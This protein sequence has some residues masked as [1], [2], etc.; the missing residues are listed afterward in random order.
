MNNFINREKEL[1]QLNTLYRSPKS[2]LVIVYGRRRLGKT[3]LLKEFSQHLP[4]CYFMAD[5][6]GQQSL[7]SNIA[8]ALSLAL[9]E[10]LLQRMEY[11]SWYDLFATFDRFR[12]KGSKFIFIID[13]YQ[14]LC[15]ADPAFSSYIQKW[16]DEKWRYD[17]I[18]FIL[19]GSVTSMMYKETLAESSPLYGRASAHILL[20]P[21]SYRH[22]Q[23]FLPGKTENDLIE[24]FALSGGVPRYMELLQGYNSFTEALTNLVL[25]KNGILYSEARYLLH[26]E[27]S[28]P[29][30]CWSILN[31]LGSGTTK[32]SEL[33]SRLGLPANQLT[34]YIDLLKDLFL[35]RREVPV[36][37]KNPAKSK[38]GI[39][40][41]DDFFIR[42]WFGAIYPYESFLEFDQIELT[43][44][45]LTPL[46]RAHI[47]YCYE[48]I[49]REFIKL[50]IHNFDVV[51]L[52]R[53][54]GKN[55][56]IDV[57]G[58]DSDNRIS[59]A[60]ECKWSHKMVGRSI[61]RDLHQ[62]IEHNHLPLSDNPT[63]CL[64]SRTGFSDDLIK[65]AKNSSTNIIL[66]GSLW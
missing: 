20:A 21:F 23:D 66:T 38:K 26:E 2:E 24:M 65:E 39:Y 36:L 56:E 57:C 9:N 25:S 14:Y 61:L 7:K 18:L 62:K 52:G 16:W 12:D 5:K 37:E 30:T 13:E 34:R 33:G 28:T 47:A 64:F 32:I 10:P 59:L 48:Q 3:Y 51:R 31:A 55:Y 15:Q 40:L 4:H 22:I 43:L 58:V 27:I 1:S 35:V 6:A 46:I 53:Q 50:N 17:N 29:N 19:C 42:L 11:P 41:V 8:L 54:W 60:G 63:Y 44:K 49:C 45:R